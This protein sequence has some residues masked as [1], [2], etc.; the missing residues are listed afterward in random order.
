MKAIATDYRGRMKEVVERACLPHILPSASEI[1]LQNVGILA[2]PRK[3]ALDAAFKPMGYLCRG[4]SGEFHL[5]R[6]TPGHLTIELYLDVGTWS[7]SVSAIFIVQGGG[8]RSRSS[9]RRRRTVFVGNTPLATPPS[10]RKSWRIW[11]RWF[12]NS[13]A[14]LCRTSRRRQDPRPHGISPLKARHEPIPTLGGALKDQEVPHFLKRS[15]E[16]IRSQ[17]ERGGIPDRAMNFRE[18]AVR[19]F[20]RHECFRRE[21]AGQAPRFFG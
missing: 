17:P 9:F 5:T 16:S 19:E 4:G 12:S 2:G 6:R 14:V 15:C 7:H 21:R 3:P 20:Q 13:S 18:R 11:P 10:G 1:G 8:V